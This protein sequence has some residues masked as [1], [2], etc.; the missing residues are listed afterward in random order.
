MIYNCEITESKLNTISY[1]I[2][3]CQHN[4]FATIQN[5]TNHDYIEKEISFKSSCMYIYLFGRI[6]TVNG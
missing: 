1:Y 3:Q 5:Q 4:L 6:H 2:W